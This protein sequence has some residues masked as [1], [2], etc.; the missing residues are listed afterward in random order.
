MPRCNIHEEVSS[1]Y[2]V[3]SVLNLRQKICEEIIS[4][5]LYKVDEDETEKE[6]IKLSQAESKR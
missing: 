5:K 3:N 6:N 2:D 1:H 4:K